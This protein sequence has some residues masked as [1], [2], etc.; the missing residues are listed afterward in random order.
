MKTGLAVCL[1][2]YGLLGQAPGL[3]FEVASIRPMVFPNEAFAAGFH[4]GATS[5]ACGGGE[6]SVSGTTIRLT[7]AG[8]C[9]IIRIAY[10]VKGYEISGVPANLGYSGQQKGGRLPATQAIAAEATLPVFFYDIEARSPG[11]ESPNDQQVREMLRALLSDRFRL[12]VHRENRQLVFLALVPAKNGTKLKP[13]SEGCKPHSGPSLMA[14]CGQ[15]M[16]QLAKY[17]NTSADQQVLDMTG[18]SGKFDYEIPI[19]R[20][21]SDFGAAVRSAVQEYLGL[22]LESRKGPVEMLVVDHVEAPSEN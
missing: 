2:A 7:K 20:A 6:L 11:A 8:I 21:E 9:D 17:L 14:L 12:K 22:K 4:A 18:L 19:D 10:N 15:T 5:N 16:E 13:A 1:F 3:T